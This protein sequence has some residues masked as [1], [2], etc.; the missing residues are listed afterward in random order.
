M[1]QETPIP[2]A[3]AIDWSKIG[4]P[5]CDTGAQTELQKALGLLDANG[6]RILGAD[7]KPVG[8]NFS[9]IAEVIPQLWV[10]G[11]DGRY[12]WDPNIDIA[13]GRA[14]VDTATGNERYVP[15]ANSPDGKFND[16]EVMAVIIA[17]AQRAQA[18]G[19]RLDSVQIQ[20]VADAACPIL[21]EITGVAAPTCNIGSGRR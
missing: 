15:T 7:G 8:A 19:V 2:T 1:T 3:P 13:T 11:P 10:E 17:V 6:N 5:V 21:N 16:P 9:R 18:S 20:D 14:Q 4:S 12:R